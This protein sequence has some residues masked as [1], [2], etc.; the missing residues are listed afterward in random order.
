MRCCFSISAFLAMVLR[1]LLPEGEPEGVEEGAPLGVVAGRGADRDVHPTCGI[2]AVVVDLGE[3]ELLAQPEGVVA[4][5]VEGAGGQAPEVPDAR[6]GQRDQ[7][8]EELPRPIPAQGDLGA[9]GH[10]L[11]Q[12][13]AGDGLAGA[14]HHGLL[15]RDDLEVAY[16]SLDQRGLLGR[17]AD[18]HVHDDLLE[19]GR[20]HDVAQ[21]QLLLELG[22]H[23]GVVALL[24]PRL[25]A[26]RCAGHRSAPHF[27]HTRS[28]RPCSSKRIPTRVGRP[29]E[30]HTT[31]TAA[32][33]NGMSLS[34]MPPC[35]V[36]P[37]G[38]VWRLA[39][40]AP[41]TTTLRCAGRAIM[42]WP[43]LPRCL[44]D[45]TCTV[46]PLRTFITA[47]PVRATRSS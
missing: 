14:G 22:A 2:D 5:A 4:P 18:T 41:S 15:A 19:P 28:L 37:R 35:M 42:T 44:P 26:Y 27:R 32:T 34:M 8:V 13:E 36:A 16:R 10:P 29:H 12:L 17:L 40:L 11:A 7:P 38:L 31:A 47:P 39:R 21:A 43:R 33:G 45:S 25:H 23:D 3:D 9:D 6:D 30:V 24:Q 1:G 20:L 46:S